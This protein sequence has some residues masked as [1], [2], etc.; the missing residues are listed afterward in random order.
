MSAQYRPSPSSSR[1]GQQSRYTTGYNGN[2]GSFPAQ[3]GNTGSFPAQRYDT[4]S[5]PAQ[6]G[7]GSYRPSNMPRDGRGRSSSPTRQQAPTSGAYRQQRG[8]TVDSSTR[9]QRQGATAG[10]QGSAYARQGGSS[11]AYSARSAQA[12]RERSKK[13]GKRKHGSRKFIISGVV[14]LVLALLSVVGMMAYAYVQGVSDNLHS[15]V[16]TEALSAALADAPADGEPMYVLLLGTDGREGESTFRS[17]TIMLARIDPSNKQVTLISIPR[18]TYV[19]LEGYGPN[20]IN[21]ARAYGGAELAI[22]TVSE[23]AGVPISHYVEVSF[24]GFGPIVDSV[25]GVEVDVAESFYDEYQ[26]GGLDAGVQTLNG[27]QALLY[28]RA[29]HPFANGDYARA[30]HQRDVVTAL[31]TKVLSCDAVTMASTIT[32]ISQY[33]TTD[34]DVSEIISLASQMKG[35]DTTTGIY[36]AVV[37]SNTDTIDGV[38]YVV[39]DE[40]AWKTMMERVDNGLSPTDPNDTTTSSDTSAQETQVM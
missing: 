38:S 37:P 11:A 34:M 2:T 20:K 14:V 40:T 21:A 29:R 39:T 33:V 18:D 1:G 17:D 24:E 13:G 25:G 19:D 7:S 10:R 27:D 8:Y 9:R 22:S 5:F 31:A 6:R 12:V 36:S 30:E 28:A 32:T 3:R 35:M 16:D 23:Y 4:G 26:D 15:G